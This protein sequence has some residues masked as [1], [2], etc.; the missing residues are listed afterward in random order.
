MRGIVHHTSTSLAAPVQSFLV[1]HRRCGPLAFDTPSSPDG[2]TFWLMLACGCGDT[3]EALIGT[4]SL[5]VSDVHALL[6]RAG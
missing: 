1:R 6:R 2:V 3:F 4:F 5:G